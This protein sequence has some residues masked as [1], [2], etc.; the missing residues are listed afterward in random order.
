MQFRLDN[1]GGHISH[2]S[3]V[4]FGFVYIKLLMG[5]D[6]SKSLLG[7]CCKLKKAASTLESA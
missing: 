4:L 2:L 3:G 5:T 1:T 7:N 6:L